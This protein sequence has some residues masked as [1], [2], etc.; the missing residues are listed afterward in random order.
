MPEPGDELVQQRL[1]K[2]K[3]IREKG[4]DPYPH[5]YHRSHTT[6]EAVA[7]FEGLEKS[8]MP[9]PLTATAQG[10]HHTQETVQIAGRVASFRSMG[11]ASFL[12][13]RDGS[14]KIQVYLRKDRLGEEK[15]ALLKEM[16]LGDF[17][18][19]SGAMFRT[20]TGEVTVEASDC[21]LLAKSVRTPPEKWHGL[22]DVEKRYRQRYLDLMSSEEV[23]TIFRVR[24]KTISILRRFLDSR[25]FMEVETPILLPLAAGAM[26]RP[27]ATRHHALDREL[28]LRIA[29]ELHLKRLIVGGFDKVYEIGRVFRNEGIDIQHNPEFT[30]LESYEAYADYNDVMAMVEQMFGSIAQEVASNL[31]LPWGDQT[32]DLTPPWRRLPLRE[33]IKEACGVDFQEYPDSASLGERMVS[34]GVPVERNASRGR[35]IDK[36]LSTYVEP[37][38]LQPTFLVDYPLDMSP[39]AK[40]KPED[41]TLVE[42]FEAYI[43]GMEIANAFTELNDPIDQRERFVEQER[44]RKEMGDQE[45]DRLDEDFLVAIEHGMPPTGGL[46]VGI[47]R[48]VMLLTNQRSIREVILFPQMRTK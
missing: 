8:V 29:T 11:K 15:Y 6:Q 22:V 31:K 33:A 34:M 27:F 3:R 13:L 23:R 19:V 26:A 20:K 41:P 12:D 37:S 17:L 16:D 36:L 43:G 42:R 48:M 24:S 47:D 7:L 46:G 40:R 18:G 5:R 35:L 21:L 32:I 25:G 28:F 1:A 14:G 4:I 38:L 44:M 2:L 10:V 45:F 9:L 39:L 30:T